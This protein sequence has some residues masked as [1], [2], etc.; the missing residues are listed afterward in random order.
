MRRFALV[1]LILTGCTSRADRL[2]NQ[3]DMMERAGATGRELCQQSK[4]IAQAYLD[5]SDE[6]QYKAA[7]TRSST[8][9]AAADLDDAQ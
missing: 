7:V 1:V 9:C 6:D 4:K 8:V 3:Y 2:Q 5:A